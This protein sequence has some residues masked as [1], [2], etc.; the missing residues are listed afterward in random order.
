MPTRSER[1]VLPMLETPPP[2][3]V[4]PA[5]IEPIATTS[6]IP[7]PVN[8]TMSANVTSTVLAEPVPTMHRSFPGSRTW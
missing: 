2:T 7:T 1:A 3:A 6:V 4:A 8:A 5:M